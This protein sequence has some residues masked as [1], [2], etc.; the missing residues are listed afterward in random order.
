MKENLIN[1]QMSEEFYNEKFLKMGEGGSESTM[2]Y[3]DVSGVDFV[4]GGNKEGSLL[5][6]SFMVKC[7]HTILGDN[8]I[9]PIGQLY[10]A[11]TS[12]TT[13]VHAL[14]FDFS[15]RYIVN[16]GTT[17]V[18]LKE[19]LIQTGWA[20]EELAAI[21]RITK[22]QFY[23]LSS[24]EDSGAL[25]EGDV[26]YYSCPSTSSSSATLKDL[27]KIKDNIV[28]VAVARAENPNT[29]SFT[30]IESFVNGENL[31]WYESTEYG[32]VSVS[33][34]NYSSLE[35]IG[36]SFRVGSDLKTALDIIGTPIGGEITQITQEE[37][38]NI[39]N[40]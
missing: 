19:A 29:G 14:A 30:P 20:E 10:V 36:F 8:A 12:K 16:T 32:Y 3:L 24:S 18:S 7:N 27:I 22:E 17:N 31:Q 28:T 21:P 38:E 15:V 33:T 5:M 13:S 37:Y 39:F 35:I 25:K 6:V 1:V 34:S 9:V 26:L 23:N 11:G 40:S 4:N 2:E